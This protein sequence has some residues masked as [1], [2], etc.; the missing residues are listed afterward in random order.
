MPKSTKKII[1]IL[2]ISL[3]FCLT[4][5]PV[6]AK[7]APAKVKLKSAKATQNTITVK[8]KKIKKAKKYQIAYKL[9]SGKK[10]SKKISKKTSCS[11]KKLKYGAK[12]QIKARANNGKWGKWS[13]V[14][15]VSTP[16]RILMTDLKS[17]STTPKPAKTLVDNYGKK[18]KS[19]VTNNH[20]YS[21]T[22]GAFNYEYLINSKYSKF[23]GTLYIPKGET[24]SKTSALIIKGDGHILYTS[25]AL[26]KIS[27]PIN[28]NVNISG[29]K[30]LVVEWTNN[31]GY[32]N[33]SD[34]ECCLANAYLY[35]AVPG[36]KAIN[37]K[38]FPIAL[39]DL[40]SIYTSIKNS[41]RLI[42]N[43]GNK[44][45]SA[46]YNRVDSSHSNNNPIFEY[47]L[48]AKYKRFTGTLYVPNGLTFSGSVTMTVIADG[49]TIYQSPQMT[50]I[51]NP[52][53]FD[54]NISNCNDLQITF[55]ERCWYNSVSDKTLCLAYA[56]LYY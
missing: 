18:Y 29:V 56:Y 2:L 21:G 27:S 24:S 3:C 16:S 6:C 14:K 53:K 47:L 31:S 20:G 4:A 30:D 33:L 44:Y 28:F 51:S 35:Y 34:L 45:S 50:K 8:W 55:T 25:P 40:T 54:I 13:K 17:I 42:D 22:S 39:T 43:N 48:N 41:S 1:F 23:T 15:T 46:I 36:D 37:I 32:S 10:W 38:S 7:K 9:K 19:A 49:K 11:I 12:Y 26:D 5:L 52:V